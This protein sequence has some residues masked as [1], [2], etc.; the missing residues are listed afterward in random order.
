VA[1]FAEAPLLGQIPI[2]PAVREWGDAGTPIVQAA[3]DSPVARAL[4]EVAYRLAGRV[5][6]HNLEHAQ[7]DLVIDRSGGKNRHLPI[8]R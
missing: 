7:D 5:S 2:H 4:T 3:P 1:E 6:A 8:A